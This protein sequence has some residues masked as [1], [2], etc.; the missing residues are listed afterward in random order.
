MQW[1]NSPAPVANPFRAASRSTVRREIGAPPGASGVVVAEIAPDSP[2]SDQGVSAGDLITE[3]NGVAV[4]S[5]AEL[6][7]ELSKVGKGEYVWLYV[8]R[9]QPQEVSRYVVVQLG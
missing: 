5:A 8:R 2:L 3:V 1:T 6:E 9:F 7:S 4:H